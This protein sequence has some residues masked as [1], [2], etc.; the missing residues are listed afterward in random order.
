MT[1]QQ[2]H[3][4][5]FTWCRDDIERTCWPG[6]VINL[7]QQ[8]RVIEPVFTDHAIEVTT[9]NCYETSEIIII[10]IISF[11]YRGIMLRYIFLVNP[12]PKFLFIFWE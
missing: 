6:Q 10:I 11:V 8:V 12:F 9:V 4:I 7:F 1:P 2:T 5:M 3:R